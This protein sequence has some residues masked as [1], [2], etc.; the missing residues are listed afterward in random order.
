MFYWWKPLNWRRINKERKGNKME[1]LLIAL[2]FAFVGILG[3]FGDALY[4][5]LTGTIGI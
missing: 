3:Q 1:L 5:R 2:S 4:R